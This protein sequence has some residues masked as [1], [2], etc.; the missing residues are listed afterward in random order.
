MRRLAAA[1]LVLVLAGAGLSWNAERLLL[2]HFDGAR[3]APEQLGLVGVREVQRGEL[4]LWVAKPA[5]GKPSILYFHGN[6]GNLANRAGRFAAFTRRGYGLVAMA[7]PGSSGSTGPQGTEAFTR[8]AADTYLAMPGLVGPGPVVLY[9]ESLGTAMAVFVS[10]SAAASAST[11]NGSPAGVVLEA[12]FTSIRDVAR[13]IYPIPDA[14][15]E[16]L[17]DIL[18]S[19]TWITTLTAPLLV[20]HGS[21]DRVVPPELGR[22]LFEAAPSPD[23]RLFIVEGAGHVDVWQPEAQR[24]LYDFLARL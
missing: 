18:P 6:A 11:G 17:P 15:I 21:A 5:P 24:V 3:V 8:A 14:L 19:Q 10:V 4:V 23:K 13:A 9:G 1:L 12:P 16:R 22:A 7:Y 2:F 20:L